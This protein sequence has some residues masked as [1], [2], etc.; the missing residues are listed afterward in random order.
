MVP[1]SM[2]THRQIVNMTPTSRKVYAANYIPIQVEGELQ[3]P[4]FLGEQCIWTDALVSEDIEEVMLGIDWLKQ[5]DCV[6]DFR[7]E[8]ISVMGQQFSFWIVHRPGTRH[9]NAD[10]LSRR[11]VDDDSSSDEEP[12]QCKTVASRTE[13]VRE[14]SNTKPRVQAPAG[15]SLADLQRQDPDI[16][17][18]LRLRLQQSNQPRPETVIS[19]SESVKVLWG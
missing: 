17:P 8:R 12:R 1:R 3:L 16:G 10:A 15:E 13:A 11:P 4:F 9:R 6:C 14:Q 18:I 5:N 7:N 19:E 2:L